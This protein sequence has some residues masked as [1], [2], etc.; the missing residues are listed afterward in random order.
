MLSILPDQTCARR[1]TAW[2]ASH[3]GALGIPVEQFTRLDHCLDEALAN[4]LAHGGPAA[5]ASPIA[6]ELEVSEER[7]HRV[8]AVTIS[9]HGL[10]FDPIAA[11][12]VPR[13][14]PTCLAEAKPG[15]LGLPMIR[16]FSD[17]LQYRYDQGRN[18]FTFAVKWRDDER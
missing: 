3:A 5:L 18:R 15:G 14:A 9:D 12:A 2:L 11:L 7:D 17:R 8:A 1:A 13:S 4:V 6:V 16:K 10:P